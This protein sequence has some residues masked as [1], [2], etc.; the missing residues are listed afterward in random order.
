[1]RVSKR[2][3]DIATLYFSAIA[4]PVY[5]QHLGEAFAHALRHVRDQLAREPMQ[6][7]LFVGIAGPPHNDS[8]VADLQCEARSNCG[9]EL[10]FRSLDLECEVVQRRLDA[11]F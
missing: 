3:I 10:A 2:Q 5:L 4:N 8:A 6:R 7:A 11:L 9:L 1:M